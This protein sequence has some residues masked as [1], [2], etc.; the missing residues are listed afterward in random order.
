MKKLG[1]I[2][3]LLIVAAP[4]SAQ[5]R[6]NRPRAV[7]TPLVQLPADHDHVR[8]AL[9]VTLPEGVHTQSNKPRDPS[10]IPTELNIDAPAGVTVDEIVWPPAPR[11]ATSAPRTC[12]RC[13][14]PSSPA[15]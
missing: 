12:R 14:K 11:A 13:E 9:R 15:T 1:I 5:T 10:L 4:L 3:A 6:A 7:V 8:L 2:A